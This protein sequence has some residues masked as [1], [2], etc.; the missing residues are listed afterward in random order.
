MTIY[1]YNEDYILK[2]NELISDYRYLK[3]KRVLEQL[4]E[5]DPDHGQAHNILGWIFHYPIEDYERASYHYQLSMQFAPRYPYSYRNY[6]YLLNELGRYYDAICMVKK[7]LSVMGIEKDIIY[8]QLGEAME[9]LERYKEAIDAYKHGIR[10]STCVDRIS[11]L[12]QGIQRIR[13]KTRYLVSRPSIV[14]YWCTE[15]QSI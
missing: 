8:Q 7:S 15:F 1:H 3:A 13:K 5:I 6:I 14:T 9:H 12:E 2:A 4:L 11:Q 10:F